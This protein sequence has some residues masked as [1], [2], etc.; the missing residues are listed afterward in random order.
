MSILMNESARTNISILQRANELFGITQRRVASG[1]SIFTSAD[2]TTR[3]K[4]SETLL[5]RSKQ[6]SDINNNIALGLSTLETTDKTL[7]TMLGL[8]ESALSL[9]SKAQNEGGAG[10][11]STL[12]T[13][14]LN[15]TS[16][17]VGAVI[18][19]K[20]SI[21]SDSGKNFTY[22]FNSV[23]TTWGEVANALNS[24]NIG[25]IAKFVPSTVAGQTNLRFSALNNEE[26]FTFDDVSDRNVMD[27]L[28]GM[29]SPSGQAFVPANLFANGVAAP[30][31]GESG[32]AVTFGGR[33]T[34]SAGGGVTGATVIPAGSTMTFEDGNGGFRSVS[35]GV[36]T[37]LTQVITDITAMGAGIKAELVNQ[38]GGAGGPLQ[39]RLRNMNGGNMKI[40]SG[41]GA[42]AP[43]G[44]LGLNGASLGYAAPLS[45]D[46]ALRLSYGQQYD[47]I[48]LSLDLLVANNPVPNGRNLLQGQNVNVILDEFA[49]NPVKISG[50][51]V[52][53]A[54]T[55]TMSQQGAT[56]TTELN[57]QNS[58]VQARQA[59]VKLRALQ[60]QFATFNTYIKSRFDLNRAYQ[61]ELKTQGDEV[62]A[63]DA[64]EESA[65]LIALKTRQDFA[66]QALTLGN[67]SD[68]SLLRLL[69]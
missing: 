38:T 17:V 27:D 47:A 10:S 23:T 36:A 63:A 45:T 19:S 3:Y 7:N 1:K 39:F 22:V 20:F 4:S 31:P 41:A 21:T 51:A 30:A 53:A 43:A 68:Q 37:T 28:T 61:G 54:G 59:V 62:V 15:A 48:I 46:N 69:G 49:G 25:V 44:V 35:Y 32:F 9:V 24:A 56:W 12:P 2:D 65:R 14:D 67:Q 55:L 5:G 13:A 42:F 18:G 33:I 29:L 58:A 8:V 60:A 40:I 34:G 66:V 50:V 16:P 52:T 6:L 64:S 26:D 11:L 57:I